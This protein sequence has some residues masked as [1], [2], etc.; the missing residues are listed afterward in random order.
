MGG[1]TDKIDP[2][3]ANF[4]AQTIKGLRDANPEMSYEEAKKQAI[5]LARK[6]FMKMKSKILILVNLVIILLQVSVD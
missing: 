6:E 2:R 3:A 1:N 5:S 4:V